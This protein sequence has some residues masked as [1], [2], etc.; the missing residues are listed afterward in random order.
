MIN[1]A[2]VLLEDSAT[3]LLVQVEGGPWPDEKAKFTCFLNTGEVFVASIVDQSAAWLGG[4][5]ENTFWQ[6]PEGHFGVDG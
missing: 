5:T 1:E 6:D 3:F 4:W 2:A